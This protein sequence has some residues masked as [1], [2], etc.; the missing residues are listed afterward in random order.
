MRESSISPCLCTPAGVI[1]SVVYCHLSTYVRM[2]LLTY[3][4]SSCFRMKGQVK[5]RVQSLLEIVSSETK[6]VTGDGKHVT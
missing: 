4:F 6:E 1:Q 5:E 3:I 2:Y